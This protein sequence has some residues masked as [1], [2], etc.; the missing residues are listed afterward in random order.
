MARNE[1]RTTDH[2]AEVSPSRAKALRGPAD[3]RGRQ[4]I[5]Q[6]SILQ[7][8]EASRRGLTITELHQAVTDGDGYSCSQRTIYRDIEQLQQAGFQLDEND[9]RWSLYRNGTSLQSWPLQPSDH[10]QGDG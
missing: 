5:R 2:T 6:L 10:T 3:A 1:G 9:G 8:L 7:L 4:V